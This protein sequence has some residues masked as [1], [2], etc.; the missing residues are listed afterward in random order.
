MMQETIKDIIN[1]L[2][3]VASTCAATEF[4]FDKSL[5]A[6]PEKRNHQKVRVWEASEIVFFVYKFADENMVRIPANCFSKCLIRIAHLE[7]CPYLPGSFV[8]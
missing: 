4:V 6:Y 5:A 2:S 3:A 7:R 1:L 8:T